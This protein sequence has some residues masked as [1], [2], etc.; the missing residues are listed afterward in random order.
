MKKVT[1]RTSSGLH[2]APEYFKPKST[3]HKGVGRLW[4][5]WGEISRT[6]RNW[7]KYFSNAPWQLSYVTHT[8]ACSCILTWQ[9]HVAGVQC[10]HNLL[11]SLASTCRSTCFS[12]DSCPCK[13][14]L[15]AYKLLPPTTWHHLSIS[16]LL[17]PSLK[18]LLPLWLMPYLVLQR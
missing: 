10:T 1:K 3:H 4:G 6:T 5:I 9:L 15:S 7:I 12:L 8:E 2:C 14:Y 11:Q 13:A 17:A 16:T 18:D